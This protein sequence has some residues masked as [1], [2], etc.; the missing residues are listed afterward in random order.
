V[1]LH[2]WLERGAIWPNRKCGRQLALALHRG[3]VVDAN[4]GS[5]AWLDHVVESPFM[6]VEKKNPKMADR[7][8]GRAL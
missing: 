2:P 4:L 3:N 6:K 8:Q 5:V 7:C 1:S